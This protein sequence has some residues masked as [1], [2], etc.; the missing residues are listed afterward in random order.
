[1]PDELMP[2]GEF[3]RRSGL[4]ASALRFYAD[5]GVLLPAEVDA[6]TGYR[7]YAAEQVE[8]AGVLR[9][10][11]E[12]RMPLGP[13]L[14]VLDGDPEQAVRLVR[15]H[16]AAVA[17]EAALA[18]RTA[19]EL[20]AA[21]GVAPEVVVG[22][23]KGP[24]LAAAIEQVLAATGVDPALP[25]LEGV[26]L[27]ALPDAVIVTATDRYRL[28]TRTMAPVEAPATNWA[29]TIAGA[30]LRAAVPEIRRTP[31]V[32]LRATAH[33]L[34]LGARS[35]RIL[36]D[37]FPDY[38]GMLAALSEIVTRVT[39]GREPLL[40]ALEEHRGGEIAMHAT[41]EPNLGGTV[42][43]ATGEVRIGGTALSATV[44]GSPLTLHFDPA[45]L[46]PAIATAIGPDLLL[47]LRGPAQPITLRSADRGDLTTLA[48]PI[49]P[50][51]GTP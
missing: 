19:A 9:R 2:I 17:A 31:V 36:P 14:R 45:V 27:E 23:V 47:D 16:A 49:H 4:T 20:E 1:M 28:S 25:V 13:V 50:R 33:R 48:M 37:D 8:R 44:M 5:T 24:V 10:L 22:A 35:C 30:D 3:A 32:A 39:V 6:V 51:N 38:R 40:R 21:L 43:P 15:E 18:Q 42:P 34:E 11:R 46:H 29:G 7:Y 26:C 12:M 41:G